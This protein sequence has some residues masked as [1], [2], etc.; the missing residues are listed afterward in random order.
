[1]ARWLYC[2]R[3]TVSVALRAGPF[4]YPLH[5]HDLIVE[6]CICSGDKETID[7]VDVQERLRDVLRPLDYKML[8]SAGLSTM[9]DVAVRVAEGIEACIVRVYTPRGMM[10]EYNRIDGT[11][12]G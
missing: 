12:T 3:E 5:G 11:S 1:M 2:A 10:I 4:N 6:A 9:E 7:L 8:E